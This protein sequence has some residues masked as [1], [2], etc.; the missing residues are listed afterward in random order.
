MRINSFLKLYY[1]LLFLFLTILIK[2][3]DAVAQ[4]GAVFWNNPFIFYLLPF[5]IIPLLLYLVN[6]KD[7]NNKITSVIVFF[8]CLAFISILYIGIPTFPFDIDSIISTQ[9]IPFILNNG[10]SV[11][12]IRQSDLLIGATYS[13]PIFSLFAAISVLVAGLGYMDAGK[14]LPFLLSIIFLFTYYV[15]LEK[16]FNIKIALL[17]LLLISPFPLILNLSGTFNNAVLAQLFLILIWWL[18]FKYYQDKKIEISL[19]LLIILSVFAFTHHLTYVILIFALLMILVLIYTGKKLN[20]TKINDNKSNFINLALF[21]IVLVMAYYMY[22]Y[23]TPISLVVKAFSNQLTVEGSGI[24]PIVSWNMEIIFQ[25]I[26]YVIFIS[27]SLFLCFFSLKSNYKEYLNNIPSLCI[28]LGLGFFVFSFLGTLLHFPF[29][30][31]RSAIFGWILFIPGSV[32]IMLAYSNKNRIIKILTICS[33]FLLIFGN[34]LNI[35]NGF[36]D[37]RSDNEYGEGY[38]NWIK[39]QEWNSALWLNNNS[40]EAIF[41]SDETFRRAYLVNHLPLIDNKYIISSLRPNYKFFD[42]NYYNLNENYVSSINEKYKF[43]I[44]RQENY[45]HVTGSFY[46]SKKNIT[47]MD[48]ISLGT[49]AKLNN[50]S[51]LNLVYDDYDVKIFQHLS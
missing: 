31:D 18:L 25:R 40:N 11:D 4:G 27:L 16:I 3:Y 9:S 47:K 35:D 26:T 51:R 24:R 43:L 7:V 20:I 13:L 49:Y 5:F 39:T 14:L 45:Y 23:F 17:S 32:A 22:V 2:G 12:F 42:M 29:N 36:I 33:I 50:D 41:M 19:L 46:S 48:N 44:F 15:M 6:I 37:H 38:K 28:I 21:A 1:S 8:V 34:V 30:W 10:F